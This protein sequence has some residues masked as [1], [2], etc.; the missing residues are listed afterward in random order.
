MYYYTVFFSADC[1]VIATM[2][3]QR[4]YQQDKQY[5]KLTDTVIEQID[6]GKPNFQFYNLFRNNPELTEQTNKI[7]NAN[8][9]EL[10]ND[11]RP[12]LEQ[13]IGKTVM[14]FIGRVFTRFSIEELFPK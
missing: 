5:L 12:T 2:N 13:T 8:M 3:G 14:E 4:Y 10:L 11:L 1:R 9:Q 7:L 6:F